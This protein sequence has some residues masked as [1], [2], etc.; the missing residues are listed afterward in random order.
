M[1]FLEILKDLY[2]DIEPWID[3][4]SSAEANIFYG[5]VVSFF[6]VMGWLLKKIYKRC[7]KSP[8]PPLIETVEEQLPAS[9]P[10]PVSN[11]T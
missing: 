10:A 3:N 2:T 8:T 6:S 1:N 9:P 4:L 5:V 7:K 11:R